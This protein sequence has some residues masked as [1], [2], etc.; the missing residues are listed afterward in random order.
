MKH[1]GKN[2]TSNKARQMQEKNLYTFLLSPGVRR[3]QGK[4][5]GDTS[6][7]ILVERNEFSFCRSLNRRVFWKTGWPVSSVSRQELLGME[8]STAVKKVVLQ[9][10]EGIMQRRQI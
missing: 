10:I 7:F 3:E 8:A 6:L 5:N 2:I 4:N 1:P 9:K